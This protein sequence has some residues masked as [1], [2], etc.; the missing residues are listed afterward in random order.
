MTPTPSWCAS[1]R[2]DRPAIPG[3][4]AAFFRSLA[5]N[6]TSWKRETPHP[7]YPGQVTSKHQSSTE[8]EDAFSLQQLYQV[9]QDRR[10]N[11]TPARTRLPCWTPDC[12]RSP[13]KWARKP[14]RCWWRR[15]RR[16]IRRL[17]EEVADLAYHLLVLLAARGITPASI[18]A[19]LAR[20]H[21]PQ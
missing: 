16:R 13:K 9:I 2:L 20:R 14:Q 12:R 21:K 17:V 6:I 18:T 5:G 1:T 7:T 8:D 15:W 10:Q 19:E 3:S 4:R 11:P